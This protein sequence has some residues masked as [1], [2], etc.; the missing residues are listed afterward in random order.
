MALNVNSDIVSRDISFFIVA[1]S[2]G[3]TTAF[4]NIRFIRVIVSAFLVATYIY[5]IILTVRRDSVNHG[6]LDKLYLTKIL[7]F[8]NNVPDILLQIGIALAGIIFGANVFVTNMETVSEYIGITPLILSLIVTPIVTELPEKFNSIIWI[9]RKKRHFGFGKYNGGNGVSELHTG[10][11][12]NS[13]NTM[14]AKLPYYSEFCN[15]HLVRSHS[16][17]LD[18]RQRKAQPCSTVCGRR[19]LCP[20][21]C[22]SVY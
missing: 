19:I 10:V 1:Y 11:N 20:L 7:G 16:I 17:F 8:K 14:E 22:L 9:A 13:C 6:Y 12:R 18:R 5:Y 4:I 3:V 21:Y 15:G 2:V